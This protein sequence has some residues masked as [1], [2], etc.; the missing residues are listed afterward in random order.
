MREIEKRFESIDGTTFATAEEAERHDRVVAAIRGVEAAGEQLRQ[1]MLEACTTADGHPFQVDELEYWYVAD[2]AY[3]MPEVMR[4]TGLYYQPGLSVG[5]DGL[6]L[7]LLEPTHDGTLHRWVTYPLSRLYATQ[8]A[9]HVACLQARRERL[10]QI[11]L[12]VEAYASDVEM[13]VTAAKER[14]R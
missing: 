14:E 11:R 6:E 13:V 9:A 3:R 12:E 1:A 8:A 10:A 4:L 7:R 5:R 2:R